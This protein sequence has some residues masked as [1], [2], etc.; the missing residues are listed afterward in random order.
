MMKAKRVLAALDTII[1]SLRRGYFPF[2]STERELLAD[3]LTPAR[4]LYARLSIKAKQKKSPS[5]AE[6]RQ[7]MIEDI[8]RK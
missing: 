8:N 3:D 1:L 5:S 7:V 4:D 6:I 2:S